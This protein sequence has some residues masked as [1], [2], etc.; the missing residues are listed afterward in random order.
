MECLFIMFAKNSPREVNILPPFDFKLITFLPISLHVQVQIWRW[1]ILYCCFLNSE[2][3][4][5]SFFP[6]G[7][8][9]VT[10]SLCRTPPFWSGSREKKV[11]TERKYQLF[12]LCFREVNIGVICYYSAAV[13]PWQNIP[14]QKHGRQKTDVK[15]KCALNPNHVWFRM[16]RSNQPR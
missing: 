1:R 10:A 8:S 14:F 5:W 3:N 4:E 12:W 13:I 9:M 11:I 6:D 16:L 2:K 15:K 7:E